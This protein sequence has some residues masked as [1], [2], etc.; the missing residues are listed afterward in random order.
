MPQVL[1]LSIY[2]V[3]VVMVVSCVLVQLCS[4]LQKRPLDSIL[5]YCLELIKLE[6][7]RIRIGTRAKGRNIYTTGTIKLIGKS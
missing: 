1:G 6:D 3:I 2:P 7:L 5:P 4:S